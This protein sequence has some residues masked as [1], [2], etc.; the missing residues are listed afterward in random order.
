[1]KKFTL[2]Y[3]E[4]FEENPKNILEIGSRDG[5]DANYI[6]EYFNINDNN[7]HI[8]EPNPS[9]NKLIRNKFP[10]YNIYDFA[11]SQIFGVI[12]F[13]SIDLSK[14]EYTLTIE[15]EKM[16]NG[17]AS[18]M[19]R[20]HYTNDPVDDILE[21]TQN[22]INVLSVDGKTLLKLINDDVYDIVKIDVEGATYN[23]LRS[24]GEDLKKLKYIH[25]EAEKKPLWENQITYDIIKNYML[26][27]GF[28]EH[29]NTEYSFEQFDTIWYNKKMRTK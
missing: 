29:Y 1:M 6:K 14:C 22:W 16:L 23:V 20:G 7:V 21:K 19:E 12:K 25:M 27:M 5:D 24:F 26:K 10:K 18:I 15:Q 11:I 9:S 2:K 8:V 4:I 13:N 28:E 17:M 3:K